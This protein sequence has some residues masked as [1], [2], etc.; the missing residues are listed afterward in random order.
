[1]VRGRPRPHQSLAYGK[2]LAVIPESKYITKTHNI[3]KYACNKNSIIALHKNHNAELGLS[4]PRRMRT[5]WSF[6]MVKY[7]RV[8]NPISLL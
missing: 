1:M 6:D 7:V 5:P 3:F 8:H 2:I 4:V